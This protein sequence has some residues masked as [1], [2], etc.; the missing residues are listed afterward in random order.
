MV[1]LLLFF[2]VIIDYIQPV[3]QWECNRVEHSCVE[4]DQILPNT[5]CLVIYKHDKW[6]NNWLTYFVFPLM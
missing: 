6:G 1:Y 5:L 2:S 3:H 4:N